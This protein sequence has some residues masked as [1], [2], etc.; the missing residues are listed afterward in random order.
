[1]LE[2]K[3]FSKIK[4]N[5][6][7][8]AEDGVKAVRF[9]LNQLYPTF[10][11]VYEATKYPGEPSEIDVTKTKTHHKGLPSFFLRC[12]FLYKGNNSLSYG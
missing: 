12:Y 9:G 2:V 8:P 4:K 6:H 5:L 3:L 1:M 7:K 11:H 10:Q